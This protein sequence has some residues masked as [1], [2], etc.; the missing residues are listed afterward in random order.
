MIF[1]TTLALAASYLEPDGRVVAVKGGSAVGDGLFKHY[2]IYTQSGFREISGNDS[3]APDAETITLANGVY[4]IPL[5]TAA[6]GGFDPDAPQTITGDWEFTGLTEFEPEDTTDKDNLS[7]KAQFFSA[8]NN[9]ANF[10]I[11]SGAVWAGARMLASNGASADIFAATNYT[12][13]DLLYYQV[14]GSAASKIVTDRSSVTLRGDINAIGELKKKGVEVATVE[15]I[16]T[17][18]VGEAPQDGKNY[19]RKNAGWVEIAEGG[20]GGIPEAPEDGK[21]YGRKNAGWEEI[22]EGGG[23]LS[24]G[25]TSTANDLIWSGTTDTFRI[26]MTSEKASNAGTFFPVFRMYRTNNSDVIYGSILYRNNNRLVSTNGGVTVTG[27][28]NETSDER[29]KSDIVAQPVFLEELRLAS[30]EGLLS[31]FTLE[32]P[33]TKDEEAD[34]IAS[35]GSIAQAIEAIIPSAVEEDNGIKQIN[36]SAMR[37]GTLLLLKDVLALVD[38]LTTEV[39]NLKTELEGIKNGQ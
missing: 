5:Q 11:S 1:D 14:S 21:K 6:S 12:S 23:G 10:P 26:G 31:T 18:P 9:S 8:P 29:Y 25:L 15:D 19:G 24:T 28:V 22:T 32:L 34:P 7:Q 30:R 4:A 39:A 27:T 38:N 35:R 37:G 20:G 36:N 17:V 13:Q 33:H 2:A 16:P 3:W